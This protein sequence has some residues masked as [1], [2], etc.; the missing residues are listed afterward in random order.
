[1]IPQQ[2]EERRKGTERKAE[3]QKRENESGELELRRDPTSLDREPILTPTHMEKRQ[4]V[5]ERER[6]GRDAKELEEKVK[7][8]FD[9]HLF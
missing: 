2:R 5:V 9:L 8:H 1:M 4:K 3:L 7:V 6:G